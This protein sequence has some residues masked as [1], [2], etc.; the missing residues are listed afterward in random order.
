MIL[1]LSSVYKKNRD[2]FSKQ[3]NDF[4]LCVRMKVF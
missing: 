2:I 4:D 3:K 1:T